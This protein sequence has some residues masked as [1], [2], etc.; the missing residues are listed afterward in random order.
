MLALAAG[1]IDVAAV[2]DAVSHP[3]CGAIL[4]FEG[5]ARDSFDGRRVV[6]L[7]YEAYDELATPVLR[8][9]AKSASEAYQAR[10]AI[11]HRLGDV[12]IGE[13]TLVVAVATPHRAA[14]YEASRAVLEALKERLPV[15]KKELYDDGHAW[16]PNA[17]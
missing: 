6:G 3:S 9:I 12:P 10:V 8:D 2:R 16:K 15:W 13:P 1:P 17:G 7:S 11:V 4:V 14:C 5:T